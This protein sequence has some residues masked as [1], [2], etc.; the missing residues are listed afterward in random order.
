MPSGVHGADRRR[1]RPRAFSPSS[2]TW[3]A[4]RPS[5]SRAKPSASCGRRSRSRTTTCGSSSSGARRSGRPGTGPI[6]RGQRALYHVHAAPGAE[7]RTWARSSSC[8]SRSTT[9]RSLRDRVDDRGPRQVPSLTPAAR[10]TIANP[11][12]EWTFFSQS[13]GA[14]RAAASSSRMRSAHR[15][16]EHHRAHLPPRGVHSHRQ[17]HGRDGA[18]FTDRCGSTPR[19]PICRLWTNRPQSSPKGRDF[20]RDIQVQPIR[21][22]FLRSSWRNDAARAVA[23]RLARGARR[24]LV[25][26]RAQRAPDTSSR[27]RT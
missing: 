3:T 8:R 10:A 15:R 1:T 9:W 7:G 22:Q 13:Q 5:A 27:Q 14:P 12:G 26:D 24:R 17:R 20:Y 11:A 23:P 2:P 4:G 6:P 16:V 25:P 21:Q 18:G 19:Y